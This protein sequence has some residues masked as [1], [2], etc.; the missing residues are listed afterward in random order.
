MTGS[1]ASVLRV[2]VLGHLVRGPVGGMAWHHLQYVLGLHRLGHD[3]WFLEDSQDYPACYDPARGVVDAD[4]TYGLAFA[5]RALADVGLAGR[6]AY[7]DAHKDRWHGPAADRA[8]ELCATAEVLL[9]MSGK[10]PA[11]PWFAAIPHRVLVDTDPL[12]TQLR[13]L[14][15]P[16]EMARA[17]GH[18]AFLTF[19]ESIPKGRSR[20][21]DDGLPWRA[22][23]QPIVLD[24][25]AG[26]PSTTPSLSGDPP[27]RLTTVMLWDS[28]RPR[29]H[30]GEMYGMKS[31]SMQAF[32][33]LPAR[34]GGKVRIELAAGGPG[35]PADE[36]RARGFALVDPL[37]VA[38]EPADYRCYLAGSHAEFSVAKQGYVASRCGW[39][40]ERSAA[41]LACGRP[42][43]VQDTGFSAW[44]PVGEG[45][46]AFDDLDGALVA[47]ED[48]LAR[49]PLHCRRARELAADFF[50][51]GQVLARLLDDVFSGEVEPA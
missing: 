35:L 4:P 26:T 44:L 33:A 10:N 15:D 43:L 25:W 19:G 30:A 46:L 7:Y 45:V 50:D 14:E 21:P 29:E 20:V 28:Y 12:F 48:L 9:D 37:V 24:A 23:R 49:Y 13:H 31:A 41:Y 39:F 18:S 22:T 32:L 16:A 3:V 27:A 6:W 47:I 8:D 42:V 34:V 1:R 40:S 2:L 17:R 38:R 36:L 51:A 5:G 11:R